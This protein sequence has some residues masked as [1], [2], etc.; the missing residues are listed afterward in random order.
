MYEK[1]AQRLI[2]LGYSENSAYRI[3]EVITDYGVDQI[4]DVLIELTSE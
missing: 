4:R 2:N 3:A 1:I